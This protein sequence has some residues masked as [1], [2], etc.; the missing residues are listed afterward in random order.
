MV[1][2]KEAGGGIKARR[3]QLEELTGLSEAKNS[4]FFLLDEKYTNAAVAKS[5][6]LKAYRRSVGMEDPSGGEDFMA[7]ES[8][9]ERLLQQYQQCRRSQAEHG[10]PQVATNVVTEHTGENPSCPQRIKAFRDCVLANEYG[11]IFFCFFFV[12]HTKCDWKLNNI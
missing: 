5:D 12:A 7:N 3:E 2:Q 9:C 10:T 8:D 11:R 4:R 1:C 6:S